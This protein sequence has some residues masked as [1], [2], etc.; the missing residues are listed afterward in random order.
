MHRSL[1]LVEA[2]DE[3]DSCGAQAAVF[4]PRMAKQ[5][6][7]GQGRQEPLFVKGVQVKTRNQRTGQL[8]TVGQEKQLPRSSRGSKQ[9]CE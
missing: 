7:W 1:P 5:E 9:V 3:G 4:A 8:G 6:N 2:E